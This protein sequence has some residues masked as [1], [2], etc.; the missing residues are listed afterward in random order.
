MFEALKEFRAKTAE[1]NKVPPYVVA[2]DKTLA[3][4]VLA[5]PKSKEELL[6]CYGF[7]KRK[8]EQIGESILSIVA[9]YA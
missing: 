3:A 5:M 6:A 4:I 2:S 9:K 7:G 8:Y 1:E